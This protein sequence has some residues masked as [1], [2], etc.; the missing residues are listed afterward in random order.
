MVVFIGTD[1]AADVELAAVSCAAG[2]PKTSRL[3]QNFDAG[4]TQE[5]H[6]AGCFPVSPQAVGD[7]G[8]DMHLLSA[9]ENRNL[10]AGRFQEDGFWS[11]AIARRGGFP[12]VGRTT[13]AQ[14]MRIPSR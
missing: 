8:R 7:A 11:N 2:R 3:H 14:L 1:D 4:V 9:C 13:T 12:G 6:I 10:P 5:V